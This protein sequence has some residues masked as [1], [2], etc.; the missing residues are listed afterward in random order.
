VIVAVVLGT[1]IVVS[2]KVKAVRVKEAVLEIEV[3]SVL[4]VNPS[5]KMFVLI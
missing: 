5:A 2:A 3:Q 4:L 1:E